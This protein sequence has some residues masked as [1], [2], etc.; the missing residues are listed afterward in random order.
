[1]TRPRFQFGLKVLFAIT[2]NIA[3]V[4]GGWK[5]WTYDGFTT[6]IGL[7]LQLPFLA[8][9]AI[10]IWCGLDR[11]HVDPSEKDPRDPA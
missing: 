8:L 2:T 1:M 3:I 4:L 9:V 6:T 5:L 7:A 11:A 10:W